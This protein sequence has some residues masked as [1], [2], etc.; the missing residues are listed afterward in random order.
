MKK[1]VVAS[2]PHIWTKMKTNRI[3]LDVIIALI[4]SMIAAAVLFGWRALLLLAVTVAS[5][6]ASEW[7][8]QKLLKRKSTIGDLSAVVTGI[9]L[10]FNFPADFPLW[11]A[12]FG[13][14][15]AIVL[16]KQVFGGI[17]FNLVN[18]ALAARG[19]L[20]LTFAQALG[21]SPATV[22][23]P[24]VEVVSSATPLGYLLE[25][26]MGSVPSILDKFLGIHSGAMG[27]TAAFALILGG[28]Y[29][30]IRKVISPL[31][32]L[33]FLG[34][35][36][37]ATALLGQNP[38]SHL[39]LGGALLGA[40]FMATD[41]TTIPL[42][43]KGCFIF[44]VGCGLLTALI[45]VFS[46]FPEGVTFAILIMNLLVPAIDSLTIKKPFGYKKPEMK[47]LFSFK[48]EVA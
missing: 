42:T 20:V 11:K 19:I 24:M 39:L 47:K 31:I 4:P 36:F 18:P 23:T 5:C 7:G 30:V 1:L 21:S 16:V 46:V 43:P 17:G 25:G 32:P 2:T 8:F 41:Y 26:N 33:T 3:M 14:F 12:A 22:L 35:L 48:K 38:G 29:L 13:S 28:L 44:A 40:I 9:L 10:A 15:I 27:E 37:A 34:T 45:R 6:I